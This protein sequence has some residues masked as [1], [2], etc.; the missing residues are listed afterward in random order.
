MS[1]EEQLFAA[2]GGLRDADAADHIC[3]VCVSLLDVPA[4]AI[5]LVCD[6]A[7]VAT[8]GASSVLARTFDEAQ[9]TVGEGPGVDAVTYGSPM[10]VEDFADPGEGRWPIYGQVMLSH[11]IRGVVAMPLTAGGRSFGALEL[12]LTTPEPMHGDRWAATVVAADLA[13]P[14][15]LDPVVDDLRHAADHPDGTVWAGLHTVARADVAQATGMVMAQL[16]I[17]SSEA[18]LR[19][20]AHAYLTGVAAADVAHAIV[21]HR[22]HLEPH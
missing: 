20:R 5:S 13:G 1:I 19:V 17:E 2:L 10:V 15:L 9:F 12:F 18:L 3:Q 16:N 14:R 22:L 6:G 7:N 21:E 8:L 11:R 4:A